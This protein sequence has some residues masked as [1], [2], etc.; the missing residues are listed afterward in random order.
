MNIDL[1]NGNTSSMSGDDGGSPPKCYATIAITTSTAKT[2][3]Q[4]AMSWRGEMTPIE[5]KRIRKISLT[6]TG[7]G[8]SP[9]PR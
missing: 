4:T 9:S 3:V 1:P 7:L 6:A 5:R 2:T 8:C